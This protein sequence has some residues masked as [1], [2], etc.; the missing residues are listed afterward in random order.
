MKLVIFQVSR[1]TIDKVLAGVSDKIQMDA[2][3]QKHTQTLLHVCKYPNLRR[4]AATM[5][6]VW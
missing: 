5:L 6:T 4:N 3:S 1:G 2:I